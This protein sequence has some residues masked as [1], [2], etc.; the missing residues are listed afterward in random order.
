MRTLH[1]AGFTLMEMLVVILI[2]GIL[3]SIAVPQYQKAVTKSRAANLQTML[4][5]V[6]RAANAYHLQYRKW[7][8]TFDQ[9]DLHFSMPQLGSWKA[10]C[11]RDLVAGATLKGKDFEISLYNGGVG[12]RYRVFAYFTT[13]KYKCRGFIHSFDENDDRVNARYNHKTFCAESYYNLACGTDCENG[14]FC[15]NVMGKKKDSYFATIYRYTM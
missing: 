2:I 6:V 8:T 14:I 13:G 15:K 12:K 7:P 11:G 9:L 1:N 10:A 5:E 3:A 4:A